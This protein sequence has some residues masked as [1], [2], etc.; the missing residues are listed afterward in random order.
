MIVVGFFVSVPLSLWRETVIPAVNVVLAQSQSEP[1]LQINDTIV[2]TSGWVE[3]SEQWYN[4]TPH[5][6]IADE[7]WFEFHQREYLINPQDLF[8]EL[9]ETFNWSRVNEVYLGY[10]NFT[11]F[12]ES[13]TED[14]LRWLRWSWNLDTQRYGISANRTVIDTELENG[15]ASI[16]LWCHIT[17]VAEY[18]IGWDLGIGDLFDLPSIS[19]GKLETYEYLSDSTTSERS[20]Y[21]HFSAP[22]NILQEEG[23]VCTAT[24][25]I[26][27][28]EQNKPSECDREIK[29]VL[30]PITEVNTAKASPQWEV[31]TELSRNTA[32]FRVQQGQ[33]LPEFMTVNSRIPERSILDLL[34][35]IR[36]ILYIIATLLV[37]LPSSV[38]G[39]R[40]IR[41]RRTYNRLLLLMVNL[42]NEHRSSPAVFRQ[43][44]HD[45]TESI[46]SAFIDAQLT[47]NQL[48]KLLHRR[49]DL[50]TRIP[51]R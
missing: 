7:F 26:A 15:V 32:I 12:E 14:P 41:R 27:P 44:M 33:L 17:H 2:L 20:I 9:Y 35:D 1:L 48:D 13:L 21:I 36:T 34:A 29:I 6:L 39:L 38:Q 19:F 28:R 31:S 46:F 25:H 10:D 51:T 3:W 43:Q 22:A 16:T 30:P 45:L 37:V 4:P 50:L 11:Q 49:D 8:I 24:I 40:M 42:Y 5:W 18:L 47:D 23:D